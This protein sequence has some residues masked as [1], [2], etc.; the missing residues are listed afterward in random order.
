M[1][2]LL[3]GIVGILIFAVGFFAGALCMGS[4]MSEIEREHR[5]Y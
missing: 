4:A 5:D 2:A 1:T 3:L